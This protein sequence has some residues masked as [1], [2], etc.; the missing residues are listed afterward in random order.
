MLSARFFPSITLLAS[1]PTSSVWPSIWYEIF[2]FIF[3]IFTTATRA[4]FAAMQSN[5]MALVSKLGP[6]IRH[7]TGDC[8]ISGHDL[9]IG[10]VVVA[11]GGGVV[12]VGTGVVVGTFGSVGVV[13][14]CGSGL[15]VSVVVFIGG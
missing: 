9:G 10:V 15:G 8:G 4:C 2:G 11:T 6:I 7:G 14:G 5:E 13:V 12:V 1:S 3:M